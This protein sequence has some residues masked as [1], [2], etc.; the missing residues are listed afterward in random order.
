[1][2]VIATRRV[3]ANNSRWRSSR[4]AII[5]K[6]EGMERVWDSSWNVQQQDIRVAVVVD[7]IH[8]LQKNSMRA[9]MESITGDARAT[10]TYLLFLADV[11]LLFGPMR[12]QVLATEAGRAAPG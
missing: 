1:M 9:G 6:L 11:C 12:A 7:H 4:A 2:L 10:L 5:A 3:N 8:S